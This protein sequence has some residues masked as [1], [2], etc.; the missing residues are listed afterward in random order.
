MSRKRWVLRVAHM[1]RKQ[2]RLKPSL[3]RSSLEHWLSSE[4][5][6]LDPLTSKPVGSKGR[7]SSFKLGQF[8][9]KD[10]DNFDSE[11]LPWLIQLGQMEVES[12]SR[13]MGSRQQACADLLDLPGSRLYR[14]QVLPCGLKQDQAFDLMSRDLTPED[15]EML[16][17]L[18]EGL[19][20]RGIA[21][22]DVVDSLPRMVVHDGAKEC[23]VCLSALE[24]DSD[25]VELPCKHYFHAACISK[26]LTECKNA[27]PICA[28]PI[29]RPAEVQ[30]V[31]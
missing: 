24:K 16:S 23:G 3:S 15:F 14:E 21:E 19:P 28:A 8:L 17:A 5:V 1:T 13:R 26:W 4:I 9:G 11:V 20:K 6:D 7:R 12:T 2:Q 10:G 22:K 18:D 30:A 29:Q 27:C 25:A 31:A